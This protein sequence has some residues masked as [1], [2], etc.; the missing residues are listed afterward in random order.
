VASKKTLNANNLKALG[1]PR[2]AELLVEISATNAGAKRRLRLELAG[3]QSPG[4][5]AKEVRKRITTIMRSRSFV[6]WQNRSTLIEDLEAQRRAIVNQ[7]EKTDPAEALELMWRFVVLANS[8]LERCDDS[9]GAVISVFHAGIRTRV[10]RINGLK[11]NS[12]PAARR[13]RLTGSVHG[14]P[15]SPHQKTWST[16]L[17]AH[18]GGHPVSSNT[19]PAVSKARRMARSLAT[20]RGTHMFKSLI[21]GAI[22]ARP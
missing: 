9:S 12:A 1:T 16:P 2:L 7:V 11:R 19:T 14:W 21:M 4:E 17:A 22:S 15:A 8:A 6:D 10:P 3:A 13:N 20:L 18:E 5:V